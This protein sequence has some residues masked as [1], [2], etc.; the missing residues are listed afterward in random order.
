MGKTAEMVKEMYRENGKPIVLTPTQEEIFN[1]IWKKQHPRNHIMCFT[2][3]GK[4]FTV[5]LAVLTRVATFAEKWAI[6]APSEKKA[7]IIM[8]YIIEHCFDNQ[9][10]KQKLEYDRKESLERMRRERSKSRIN[11][12]HSDK[13]LGEVFILSADSRSKS[14]SGD[15]LMGF[16]APNVILDE[17]A[18]IDNDIEAKIF[19]M[20]GD[21]TENFYF[22]I[23]NPFRR[24][25]FLKDYRDPKFH[26]VNADYK[27]GLAENRITEDFMEEAMRKP[28]FG[29][30]YKNRFPSADAIDDKGWSYLVTDT[31]YELALDNITPESEFGISQLGLD[32]A[33]GGGNFNVWVKRSKNYARV[34]A[35]NQDPDLMRTVG[36][37][38][39]LA[40]ENSIDMRNV[41]TDD[42]GVGAGVTDR[43][44]EQ[45]YYINAV[46]NSEK[47]NDETKFINRRAE[48]YWKTKEWINSGGKLCKDD[49]W[50]DLLNIKYK[51][52]SSGRLKIMS[53][54]DMRKEGIE[55]PDTSDALSLT[56]DRPPFDEKFA[57]LQAQ[58]EQEDFDRYELI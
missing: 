53:K 22:K 52:D 41:S 35:R 7:R 6:V 5:A 2:R 39:R 27:R 14:K 26:K 3:F 19:R 46:K 11:F 10:T 48:N 44:R 23:G 13:T 32:I 30:L 1:L 31:E 15:S 57:K 9:Y 36:G 37:T 49:D 25:H 42:I 40:R 28:H 24:N 21:Q 50:S 17:A 29:V 51:A 43:L 8:S 58:A 55:S 4:S 54:E 12:V 45:K 56:F 16:G 18:L 34:L 47:A 20:L 38:I 33:R